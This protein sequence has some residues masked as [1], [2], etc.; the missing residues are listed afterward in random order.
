MWH[1]A[2]LPFHLL[3]IPSSARL[4]RHIRLCGSGNPWL[5]HRHDPTD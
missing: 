3:A 4:W 2:T 5:P 1:Q